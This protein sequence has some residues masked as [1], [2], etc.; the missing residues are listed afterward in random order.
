MTVSY[1]LLLFWTFLVLFPVYWL[2]VTAFKLPIDVNTGPKY[3]MCGLP[4]LHHVWREMFVVATR[5]TPVQEHGYRRIESAVLAPSWVG[6]LM[7]SAASL[8]A[9]NPA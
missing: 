7:P 5:Y 8:I 1:I 2:F 3:L 4:S 6:P 9:R